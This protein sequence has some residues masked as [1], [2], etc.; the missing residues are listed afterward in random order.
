MSRTSGAASQII[1]RSVVNLTLGCLFVGSMLAAGV[2]PLSQDRVD[3]SINIEDVTEI[4][5]TVPAAPVV[6]PATAGTSD[7]VARWSPPVNDGGSPVIRYHV[8]MVDAATG[9]TDIASK[10]VAAPA[11]SVNFTGLRKGTSVRFEVQAVN[12]LGAS[13]YSTR[14]N[15][16]TVLG[17]PPKT[18]T[19]VNINP[20]G[21][22]AHWTNS[23][24]GHDQVIVADGTNNRTNGRILMTTWTWTSAGWIKGGSWWAWGGSRG[25]AKASQGD[26]KSPTGVFS[27]MDAGGYYANPGTKLP[28]H[29]NPAGFSSVMKG[30][31]VFSYVIAIG[32]NHVTGTS[33]LSNATPGRLSK[34]SHIWIHEGHGSPSLGCLGVSRGAVRAMLKWAN[35]AARPVIL[36][37]PH[38]QVVRAH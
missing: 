38:S 25:W 14:S 37:G 9:M 36:M 20:P 6:M 3:S 22:G 7:A 15:P 18:R 33:P 30:H 2:T 32:Y 8:S 4:T 27:L 11:T 31:R 16:V 17:A 5:A 21:V 26:R 23:L 1:Q 12:A 28:Y 34:G 10:D 19:G 35:P 13:D 24:R 29:H